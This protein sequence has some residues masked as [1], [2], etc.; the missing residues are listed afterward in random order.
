MAAIRTGPAF[1]S[2]AEAARIRSS[3][4]TRKGEEGRIMSESEIR[5]MNNRYGLVDVVTGPIQYS[6]WNI[7]SRR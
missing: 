2:S 1:A 3:S 5:E 4:V 7:K 6:L